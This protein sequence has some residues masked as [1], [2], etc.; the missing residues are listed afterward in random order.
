MY[1]KE[2]WEEASERIVAW[3]RREDVDR[4]MLVIH[5][6]RERPLPHPPA[7]P[8]PD[9]PRAMRLDFAAVL[10]R[11][12]AHFAE[13][14]YLAEA[15]P[16]VAADLGP[17][18][19]GTFLGAEP[20]FHP[21]TVWY[22]PR[23]ASLPEAEIALREDNPWWQWTLQ[24]T[25]QA[26]ARAAG[27]YLVAV[28]DLIENLDTLAAVVGTYPLLYALK[29]CPHEV[30]RLQR[31]LVPAW[32]EI[33][34]RLYNIIAPRGDGNSFMAFNIWSPG[35]T[36]KLQCDFSA[37]IS[38]ETFDEFVVPYM[39]QQT[40]HLDRVLYHLDGPGAI[41]HLPS[42]CRMAR[43]DAIQWVPGAGAPGG[44]DPCWD[45]IYRQALDAGKGIM[46]HMPAAEVPA[47]VQRFGR[48][49][50]YISV[51]DMT[52]EA[53]GRELIRRVTR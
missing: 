35:K 6:P 40:R 50:V 1:Y 36:A 45:F 12:E 21:N 31:Q 46:A 22:R 52:S 8:V 17:G 28:P 15:F 14:A 16:Y 44:G 41:Q 53:E 26:V 13:T 43:I 47:F 19:A 5:A 2:D 9:D 29:D 48:R 49:G 18:S 20:V 4:P 11:A 30:Y 51:G 42:L 10:A 23:F 37:M 32:N 33:F 3:W 27:R 24:A 25:R 38:A 7:P 34:D 39:E